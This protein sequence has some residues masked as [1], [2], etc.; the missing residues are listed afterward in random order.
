MVTPNSAFNIRAF[1]A[2]DSDTEAAFS[3][4]ADLYYQ[5]AQLGVIVPDGY[6]L[7]SSSGVFLTAPE[8]GASAPLALAAVALLRRVRGAAR[9]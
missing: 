1:L 6:S 5:T 3:S 2:A 9:R 8:S 4:I 7:T